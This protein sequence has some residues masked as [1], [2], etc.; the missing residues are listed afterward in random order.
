MKKQLINYRHF[1]GKNGFPMCGNID[2]GNR[3]NCTTPDPA[4][5]ECPRCQRLMQRTPKAKKTAV[6]RTGS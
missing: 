4:K 5:V 3:L 6:G 1:R 2:V